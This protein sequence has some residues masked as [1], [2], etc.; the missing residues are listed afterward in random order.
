MDFEN[1]IL[2]IKK[3]YNLISNK[4]SDVNIT[5]KGT[6]YGVSLPWVVKIEARESLGKTHIEAASSLLE[7]LRKELN[8]KISDLETQA[9]QLKTSLG[10]F[11]N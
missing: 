8:K 2:T 6:G 4:D 10:S 7:E 9:K 3:I 11:N 1:T 5:Y